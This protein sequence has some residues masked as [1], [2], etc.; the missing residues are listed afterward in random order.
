MR[1]L[2]RLL[3]ISATALL[4][5]TAN[6][7][8]A[9]S[10][11]DPPL[12]EPVTVDVGA[13]PSSVAAADVD[14]DGD[15]DLIVALPADDA[16]AV[17]R[18]SGAGNFSGPELSPIG[19]GPVALAVLDYNRDGFVDV[20]AAN[21]GDNSLSL[22][23]GNGDGT[24]RAGGTRPVGTNPVALAVGD[25]LGSQARPARVDLAV[26]SKGAGSVRI[27]Y[28]GG[29]SL[30]TGTGQLRSA[31]TCVEPFGV[32]TGYFESDAAED[33][34]IICDSSV[35]F[36]FERPSSSP[37]YRSVEMPAVDLRAIV[38]GE[39]LFD[40]GAAN[41]RG[42][43]SPLPEVAV[44]TD[45][46]ITIVGNP[47]RG[48]GL[49][50]IPVAG[51]LDS[52]VTADLNRDGRA[53]L[54]AANEA[55]EEIFVLYSSGP[56]TFA[57]PIGYAI[58]GS[59]LA[60]SAGD[61]DGDLY[62][63]IASAAGADH[64][65]AITFAGAHGPPSKPYVMTIL[66]TSGS[67]SN[68]TGPELNS[69]GQISTRS[70]DLRCAMNQVFPAYAP[71]VNF[72]LATNA[73]RQ[74]CGDIGCSC[75][76]ESVGGAVAGCGPRNGSDPTTRRGAY[77]R[78]PIPQDA[79][80][81]SATP[82]NN[83]ADLLSWVDFICV[84][85][86]ELFT[87]GSLSLNG[88][89]RD[90]RRY[91]ESGWSDPGIV[92]FTTPLTA[93]ERTCRSVNVII[94]SDGGE[95]DGCDTDADA[96]AAAT[97]MRQGITVGGTTFTVNT[98]VVALAD[99]PQAWAE[100]LAAAGG[101]VARYATDETSIQ[102]AY[103]SI[104]REIT[105]SANA[106]ESCDAVDEN[107]N[108]CV[109]EGWTHGAEARNSGPV[110][111]G[112]NVSLSANTFPGA[113]YT[114]SGPNGFIT[115]GQRPSLVNVTAADAG[116]YTFTASVDG[117]ITTSA[118]T[119]VT[120]NEPPDPVIG[121]PSQVVA[122]AFAEASVGAAGAGATYAWSV[123]NA[124]ITA[125]QGT[126]TIH[127]RAGTGGIVT[128]AITVTSATGCV[129]TDEH[130]IEIVAGGPFTD[131][132]LVAGSTIIKSIHVNEVR[133]A[134]NAL[135]LE[136]GL[137]QFTWAETIAPG[138]TVA[139]AHVMELRTA[140]TPAL[141]AMGRSADYAEPVSAGSPIKASHIQEIREHTR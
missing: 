119:T 85:D 67:M 110:C 120:V 64:G 132:P 5:S 35:L 96:Q 50:N 82:A 86:R 56:G 74:T 12:T 7:A 55:G 25:F 93:T 68:H 59:P 20:A 43:T 40:T 54:V 135:R 94:I 76:Y 48:G 99:A 33:L 140:L 18:N 104:L 75:T 141:I 14:N 34:A 63:D 49:V 70:N 92:S 90:T 111:A 84:D 61:L 47:A 87:N 126:A 13:S 125:G 32:A 37:V 108:G 107:C 65:V 15:Q 124:T 79:Y 19:D 46:G 134:V 29:E 60:L 83:V 138:I 62:P 30:G 57:A 3:R 123:S 6:P 72:G 16:I 21:S 122:E 80:W 114:W 106:A 89:L 130:A 28:G 81:S 66:D 41:I 100:A 102:A 69:C 2:G 24:F 137:E 17:L 42:S 101:T 88:A 133:D 139:A 109:D 39:F 136:A 113:S 118:S 9:Q 51:G 22:I 117:C 73:V 95:P 71:T 38:T 8:F 91:L 115:T 1:S 27:F 128:V 58:E 127:F 131:D 103:Q 112:S 52:L 98:Y 121:A 45:Q 78:V 4:F 97:G 31:A 77:I 10:C 36:S 129:G 11:P 44:T 26:V 23:L 53:D 116:I 105:F